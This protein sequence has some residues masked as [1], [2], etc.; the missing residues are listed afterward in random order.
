MIAVSKRGS[1]P[2]PGFRPRGDGYAWEG[3]EWDAR[4]WVGG[5]Q[6]PEA[7]EPEV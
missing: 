5:T 7:L 6:E 3:C 4:L 1:G 2:G